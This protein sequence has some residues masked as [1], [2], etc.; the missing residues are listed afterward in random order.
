MRYLPPKSD[1]LRLSLPAESEALVMGR[2]IDP[3]G[4]MVGILEPTA[5]LM[6]VNQLVLAK[7]L[8]NTEQGMVPLRVLNPSNQ[9]RTVYKN[10]VATVCEP[11]D[12]VNVIDRCKARTV[13][14]EEVDKNFANNGG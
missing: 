7:T 11:V 4:T 1:G 3:R 13:G 14:H 6:V 9:P 2:V 5:R 10:T 12:E 8:V